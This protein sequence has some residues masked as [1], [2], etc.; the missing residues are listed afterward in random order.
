MNIQSQLERVQTKKSSKKLSKKCYKGKILRQGYTTKTGKKVSPG[1]I[2]ATSGSGK[3][4]SIEIKKYIQ[5][6]ESRQKQARQKF[7]NESNKECKPGQILR[8]G[9]YVSTHKSHS[10][11]GKETKIKSF[12]VKPG[13]V[14]SQLNRNTKGEK[15]I[16]LMEKDILKSFGYT[17]VE[18]MSKTSRHSAL[19]KAIK[20]IK[21]LSIYRRVVAIATLNKNKNEK[22]YNIL[23]EDADWIK[24]QPEYIQSK[25]NSKVTFK[26]SPKSSKKSS[27]KTSKKYSK[28]T[29]KKT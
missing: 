21:P 8:E 3:K 26:K 13:C 28:K 2:E 1:C 7:P 11:L 5:K 29:S 24:T 9:Y 25:K 16:I 12:W 10:K 20:N 17:N 14:D 22:L 18:A 19:R 27:K 6:K 23:R 15:K 4:T